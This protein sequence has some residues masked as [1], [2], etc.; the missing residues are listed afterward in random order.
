MATRR[1]LTSAKQR[2]AGGRHERQLAGQAL[3]Q[4]HPQ[5]VDVAPGVEGA[6]TVDGLGG[7]V[8]RRAQQRA[9][10]RQPLAGLFEFTGEAEVQEHRLAVAADDDVA[11]LH[12]AV[13]QA[14]RMCGMQ[15][16][17]D[18]LDD[19]QQLPQRCG[20]CPGLADLLAEARALHVL[21]RQE[22]HAV[23]LAGLP[24]RADAR[25]LEPR[26]DLALAFEPSPCRR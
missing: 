12:V 17:G 25:M 15:S 24:H 13:H 19:L 9:A 1:T 3:E 23:H 26:R 5:G 8:G 11:G 22:R 10:R 7:E 18:R 16:P 14:C 6:W 21:H 20:I 2:L 4:R